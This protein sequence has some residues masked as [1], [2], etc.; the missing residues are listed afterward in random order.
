MAARVTL[1]RK[2]QP[3]LGATRMARFFDVNDCFPTKV[4]SAEAFAFP[5]RARAR[6]RIEAF[7]SLVD[8]NDNRPLPNREIVAHL[9]TGTTL[10]DSQSLTTDSSGRVRF[11]RVLPDG[12]EPGVADVVF[13]FRGDTGYRATMAYKDFRVESGKPKAWIVIGDNK[14]GST[15][16]DS[17]HESSIQKIGDV[18]RGKGYETHTAFVSG[19]EMLREIFDDPWVQAIYIY[20]H[21]DGPAGAFFLWGYDDNAP[22]KERED[23]IA[24]LG[25][26]L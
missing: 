3:F 2:G 6:Q 16:W 7:T 1:L 24:F 18:F 11:R 14:T 12:I 17:D 25:S 8:K 20:A 13:F 21:W 5:R 22:Q 9:Y 10:L 26:D 15:K 19:K 4:D 23:R